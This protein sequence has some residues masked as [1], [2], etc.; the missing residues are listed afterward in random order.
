MRQI[1]LGDYN[2]KIALS[3]TDT[4]FPG[5]TEELLGS[6]LPKI[7][8]YFYTKFFGTLPFDVD[9]FNHEETKYIL[10]HQLQINSIYQVTIIC[11]IHS[12]SAK[13]KGWQYVINLQDKEQIQ[14]YTFLEY[15]VYDKI[16]KLPPI[17]S[18][19]RVTTIPRLIKKIEVQPVTKIES[20]PESLTLQPLS[21]SEKF[22]RLVNALQITLIALIVSTM[23][24]LFIT[25]L[26]C[27]GS[28]IP[29]LVAGIY[30][31]NMHALIMAIAGCGVLSAITLSVFT[32]W[33]LTR[34]SQDMKP[35]T[36]TAR[37]A[38]SDTTSI[39]PCTHQ[40]WN[41]RPYPTPTNSIDRLFHRASTSV[42][43]ANEPEAINQSLYK[44]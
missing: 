28:T 19:P 41:E 14:D 21:F 11:S 2:K 24:A 40:P 27:G 44:M 42:K 29:L 13:R 8:L 20:P 12:H 22:P 25:A 5:I 3:I 6:Y 34:L 38:V 32:D 7:G 33:I 39:N 36:A 35:N 43:N 9:T 10:I 16:E 26:I 1:I 18:A 30:G 23:L 17:A 4:A 15:T 31:A 37:L